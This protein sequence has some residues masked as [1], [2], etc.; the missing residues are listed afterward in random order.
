MKNW[1]IGVLLVMIFLVSVSCSKKD[2]GKESKKEEHQLYLI[3]LN[4][5]GVYW[6]ALIDSAK[7]QAKTRG[8]HLV[9]KTGVPGDSSR[10]QKL[11]EMMQEA[12]DQKV[13]GIAVAALDPDM[14]DQKAAE[15]MEA[16]I[17]IVTYDTDIRNHDNR[18]SYIGTNNYEAGKKLGKKGAEDLKKRGITKGSLTAVTYSGYAQNMVERY[19]GVKDGFKEAMGNYA[20]DFAWCDWIINELSV[21]RAREQFETRIISVPDLKAV[22][23]LGTES[24]T[25]GT[26]E[27][28]KAQKKQN[29]LFHYGF[30]YYP[31][32]K[33]GAEEGL[34]TGIV[35][36]NSAET[37]KLM[38][39]K[40]ADAVEGETLN[41][42]Y[43]VD[44]IWIG[45]EELIKY[46][47]NV[48]R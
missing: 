3:T 14:F 44:V 36:Q 20:Q 24:V 19:Q 29:K 45:A 2:A 46:D 16:G 8:Y 12:I 32:L 41:K 10:T 22:F 35:N 13:D 37:G 34:I 48:E 28:I 25:A 9:I 15:A 21:S 18:L 33:Q 31:A 47:E 27:A 23:T 17:K 42:E 4:D 5:Q 6:E 11:I 43:P 40:L 7:Q 30:D 26:M 39:D 1:K 38:I